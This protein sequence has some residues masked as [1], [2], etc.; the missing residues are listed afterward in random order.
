[1]LLCDSKLTILLLL[2]LFGWRENWEKRDKENIFWV[3]YVLCGMCFLNDDF[4]FLVG[5]KNMNVQLYLVK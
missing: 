2:G 4:S 5:L 3:I 1:M